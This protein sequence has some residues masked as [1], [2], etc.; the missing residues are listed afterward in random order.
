MRYVENK[1]MVLPGSLLA[2]NNYKAGGFT[3]KENG[4]IYSNTA[5]LVYFNS[6]CVYVI[7]FKNT[8]N[9]EY[10]DLVIGRVIGSS[11]SSWTIDINS[12]YNGFLLTSEIYD[13]NEP[14]INNVININDELLLRVGNV[15]EIH[16]VKLTL[17]SHGLG[18]FNQ[19]VIVDVKQPTIHFLSEENA[20]L[21][22][23]I[24]EYTHTDII[25]A[26]N[27]LI[28][29]NGLKE[30]IEKTIEIIN[31]IEKNPFKYNLIKDVQSM[32]IKFQKE[33]Y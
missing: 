6:E 2:D 15:D 21:T 33:G 17:R 12:A 4:K 7:P 8:Y 5:G 24:Q 20:F 9:P 10:G 13:K 29:L 18:K 22:N 16:R 26:K 31:L 28:W 11:Y 27:G 3:F 30:N 1:E 23:M 14:N 19:G 32:L 25:V